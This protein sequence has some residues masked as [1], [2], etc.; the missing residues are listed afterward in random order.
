MCDTRNMRTSRTRR[1]L[2]L[3]HVMGIQC[4]SKHLDS[5]DEGK[6]QFTYMPLLISV[7]KVT[8]MKIL[9]FR[10][11]GC[12]LNHKE[13]FEQSHCIQKNKDEI[14][15]LFFC[16]CGGNMCNQ[17]ITYTTYLKKQQKNATVGMYKVSI[18]IS[19]T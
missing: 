6:L 9:T 5:T 16:C 10:F 14:N 12:F 19:N 18:I 2:P 7:L 3:F 15:Q 1:A 17:N 8:L 13:C 11:K 4:L